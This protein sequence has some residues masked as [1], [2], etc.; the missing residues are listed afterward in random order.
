MP[1]S[2]LPLVLVAWTLF[3]ADALA[4]PAPKKPV[5]PPLVEA[6]IDLDLTDP[7]KAPDA[8]VYFERPDPFDENSRETVTGLLRRELYRQAV[9]LTARD[10]FGLT[11]RDALLG[12][13]PPEDLPPLT[14]RFRVNARLVRG[15]P[16]ELKVECGPTAAS[17]VIWKAEAA[18]PSVDNE[19]PADAMLAAEAYSRSGFVAALKRAGF[20]PKPN[21]IDAKASVPQEVENLV[22]QMTFTAQFA[23]VRRLHDVIRTKGESDATL[24][25]LSRAYANLGMLTE[26]QW[27][28]LTW[29]F[30]ARGLLYAERLRQRDPTSPSGHWVRAYAGAL[31]GIHNTALDDLKEADRV[32]GKTVAPDWV[33]LVDALCRFDG[34]KLKAMSDGPWADAAAVFRF[35]TI[36]NTGNANLSIAAGRDALKRAPECYRVHDSL[37]QTGGVGFM[38]G[39][40]LAGSEELSKTLT[41][42][43]GEMPGLPESV[44]GA[45]KPDA[46]ESAVLD[47]L[48]KAGKSREDKGEPSWAVL[49]EFVREARFVQAYGRLVFLKYSLS[50]D[51]QEYFDEVKPVLADHPLFPY[52]E[53]FLLHDERDREAIQKKVRG[54]KVPELTRRH[55]LLLSVL[56]QAAPTPEGRSKYVNVALQHGD[57]LYYDVYQAMRT[58]RPGQNSSRYARWMLIHSPY[59]P[60][61]RASLIEFDWPNVQK[62]AAEWEKEA[63]DPQVFLALGRRALADGRVEDAERSLGKA[64]DISPDFSTYILLA[65]VYKGKGDTD[66][67]LET[68][69]RFLK[70]PDPGLDHARV[71]VE[72]AEHYMAKKD[73]KGAEAYANAA[74]ETYAGWAMLCAAKC[75]E[76]QEDWVTAEQ[77]VQRAAERYADSSH[78]WFYWCLRTGRGN[79]PAAQALVEKRLKLIGAPRTEN[80]LCLSAVLSAATGKREKAPGLFQAAYGVNRND[81]FTLAAALE[82]QGLGD[83]EKRDKAFDMVPEKAAY[84]PLVLLLRAVI[85]KGEKEVP[86]AEEIESLLK[87]RPPGQQ[88]EIRYFLGRFL[89]Q[90]GKSEAANELLLKCVEPTSPFFLTPVL[91]GLALREMEKK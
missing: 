17:R 49:A 67:W 91:A 62:Q 43:V 2:R 3:A 48:R 78:A 72:I 88:S 51:P 9:L 61:A 37:A 81:V 26:V 53:T 39:S 74:A 35:L 42:R 38:H 24:G 77:W 56:A 75:A 6:K 36:E 40:T 63:Q 21:P 89:Q 44:A 68:L 84:R 11:T 31:A 10:E 32:R 7:G 73:Y 18:T 25:A 80:D 41:T 15:S 47:A 28:G 66:K 54:L 5:N 30:K 82:Y 58:F 14:N 70:E 20:K 33:G 65:N 13:F 22:Q 79:L 57:L 59:A 27:G 12:E 76:G 19:W 69:E 55:L 85:A 86:S 29:A 16:H 83:A 4:Q 64:I 90:R 45:L 60:M 52:L 50:V 71:R 34:A 87:G 23:A 46:P 8:V 1:S